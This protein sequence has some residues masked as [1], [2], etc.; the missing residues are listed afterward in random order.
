MHTIKT[1]RDPYDNGWATTKKEEI[2]FKPGITILVG[3]NGIGKSTLLRNIK[4]QLEEENIPYYM[5]DNLKDGGRESIGRMM[6]E[7]KDLGTVARMLSA[8]EGENISNNLGIM[9]RKLRKFIVSGENGD[10]NFDDIF[11]PEKSKKI[12]SKERWILLDAVDSGYSIDNVVDLKSLFDLVLSDAKKMDREV[13]IVASANEYELTA[14]M[15]CLDV[16][17]GEYVTFSDYE[18]FRTFI[19]ESRNKKNVRER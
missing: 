2:V 11:N 8:S 6:Y 12:T 1:W 4:S 13:Y 16:A 19:L 9:V 15:D 18:D 5:F 17:E 7:G 10:K 3:C 14:D